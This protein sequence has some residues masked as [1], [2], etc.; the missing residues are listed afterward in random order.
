MC[1]LSLPLHV[2]LS[3][4]IPSPIQGPIP[5]L[6]PGCGGG[7]TRLLFGSRW[8]DAGTKAGPRGSFVF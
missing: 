5:R 3:L 1:P 4:A 6:A 7:W 8:F 2:S